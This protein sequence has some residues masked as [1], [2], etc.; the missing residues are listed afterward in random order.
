MRA[1]AYTVFNM[2][3]WAIFGVAFL[4]AAYAAY[5]YLVPRAPSLAYKQLEDIISSAWKARDLMEK[6]PAVAFDVGFPPGTIITEDF[7]RNI[8]GNKTVRVEFEVGAGFEKRGTGVLVKEYTKARYVAAC[9]WKNLCKIWL[10]VPPPP[11]CS[12]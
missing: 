5:N 12:K 8:V 3:I 9:C 2:L 11:V 4:L 7:V 6:K 1:Q 10:N